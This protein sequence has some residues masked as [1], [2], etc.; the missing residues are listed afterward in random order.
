MN[1]ILYFVW[2]LSCFIIFCVIYFSIRDREN[3][4]ARKWQTVIC[5]REM[6]NKVEWIIVYEEDDYIIVSW[7]NQTFVWFT[8]WVEIYSKCEW[9]SD[10]VRRIELSWAVDMYETTYSENIVMKK[11]EC[12]RQWRYKNKDIINRVK[13]L[14]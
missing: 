6:T 1:K 7:S 12:I 8:W 11:F 9:C 14:E 5:D 10:D 2:W 4:F 3:R 13:T